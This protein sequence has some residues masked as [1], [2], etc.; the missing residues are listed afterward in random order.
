MTQS[1]GDR[2]PGPLEQGAGR[3]VLPFAITAA[4]CFLAAVFPDGP[5]HPAAFVA[6]MVAATLLVVVGAAIPWSRLPRSVQVIPV[7]AGFAVVALLRHG[8]DGSASGMAPLV[9]LPVIWLALHGSRLEVLGSLVLA[10]T[11]IIAPLVLIGAPTYTAVDWRKAV[12]ITAVAALVALVVNRSVSALEAGKHEAERL[13]AQL[14]ASETNLAAMSAAGRRLRVSDDIRPMLVES[15]AS[16]AG[17]EMAMLLEPDGNGSLSQ[18]AGVGF[19]IPTLH[20]PMGS[21]RSGV[22][23][24]FASGV[25]LFAADALHDDRVNTSIAV[26]TGIR[27][28]AFEPLVRDGAS[29]G[30]LVVGWAAPVPLGDSRVAAVSAYALEATVALERADGLRELRQFAQE[31]PLTGAANRRSLDL[32]LA[33]ELP[34]HA[35]TQ[36]ALLM[37]DVD[38]FKAYNDSLGHAAGDR[39]LKEAV[40][41]WR[42]QLRGEDL[43]A[44]FG[45]EEFAILLRGCSPDQ[46]AVIAERIR[47]ATP[48]VRTI[49]MGTAVARPG[50]T[51]EQLLLRADRALYAA[52]DAGRNR[53][54][55]SEVFDVPAQLTS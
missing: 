38:H 50:E 52:K 15:V 39:L 45:G 3:R 25:G 48:A 4:V 41:A 40:A 53:V 31:D 35:E 27:S 28:A 34:V 1:A 5:S 30:V 24:A 36:R 12:V 9:L 2:A 51:G 37:V 33:T 42:T 16:L 11:T 21:Q 29:V 54:V 23:R 7:V 6:A 17:A 49:S 10:A 46:V 20:V 43:L 18:T 44:R 19:T 8:V 13:A 22:V 55:S 32:I 26:A 14:A 47:T